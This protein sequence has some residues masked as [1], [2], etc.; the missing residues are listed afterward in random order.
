MIL[1]NLLHVLGPKNEKTSAPL[2]SSH[3]NTTSGKLRCVLKDLMAVKSELS[4]SRQPRQKIA[5]IL[6]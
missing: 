6:P 5:L 1:K 3:S 2:G 4:L